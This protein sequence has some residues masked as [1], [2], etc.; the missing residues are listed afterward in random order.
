M[1]MNG[2]YV[3]LHPCDYEV[4]NIRGKMYRTTLRQGS[5]LLAL[6]PIGE[7]RFHRVSPSPCKKRYAALPRLPESGGR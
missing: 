6:R 3:T 4:W 1:A 5:K 7:I 2:D